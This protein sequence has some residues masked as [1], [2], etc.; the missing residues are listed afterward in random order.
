MELRA[1]VE[2]VGEIGVVA[3][4]VEELDAVVCLGV[5]GSEVLDEGVD[6][7]EVGND[8]R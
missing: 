6:E 4:D 5:P 3:E 1:G 8:E 2:G 7:V